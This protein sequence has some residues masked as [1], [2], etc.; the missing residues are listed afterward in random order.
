MHHISP[1]SSELL[2]AFDTEL[3][4]A[5]QIRGDG[6]RADVFEGVDEVLELEVAARGERVEGFAKD[7]LRVYKAGE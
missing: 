6:W 7:V 2:R 1:R 3:N 4:L 5:I